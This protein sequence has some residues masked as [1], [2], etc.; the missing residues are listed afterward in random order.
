MLG[1]TEKQKPNGMRKL[2]FFLLL[3]P[4]VPQLKKR[5]E[6]VPTVLQYP[7][8]SP[9]DKSCQVLMT[10]FHVQIATRFSRVFSDGKSSII[11]SSRFRYEYWA[12]VLYLL[13]VTTMLSVQHK[14]VVSIPKRELKGF[15]RWFPLRLSLSSSGY[16]RSY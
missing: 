4:R 3:I 14:V 5:G 10:P 6:N 12:A 8:R 11:L 16:E 9:G 15:T 1:S 2:L 13:T 7:L